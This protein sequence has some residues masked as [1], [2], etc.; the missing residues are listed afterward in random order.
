M[1]EMEKSSGTR[2]PLIAVTGDC[3]EARRYFLKPQYY[4]AVRL[5]GGVPLIVEYPLSIPEEWTGDREELILRQDPMEEM[6]DAVD[7]IMFTGGA[8]VDPAYYGE[9]P[10]QENGLV[11][12][13]RDA[14]EIRLCREAV[15]R[16]LPVLGICR[17]IQLLAVALGGRLVQDIH[18]DERLRNPHQ[19]NQNTQDWYPTHRV[20]TKEGSRLRA[21]V[22]DN[23]WVNSFHH[24]CVVD[25]AAGTTEAAGGSARRV[26]APFEVTAWS[27][28]G[29]IEG[30]EKPELFYFVGVQWHPERMANDPIQRGLFESFTRAA[31]E[32]HQ[33]RNQAG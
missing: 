17:G 3:E 26:P 15:K 13:F 33:K 2:R 10:V 21:I 8:D 29:L 27:Q 22:G 28:D 19:H 11:D 32:Y 4:R 25:P 12:P 6:L 1:K 20:T 31:A 14:F 16:N 30:I 7:G 18:V 9:Q 23:V 5:A 24:Q